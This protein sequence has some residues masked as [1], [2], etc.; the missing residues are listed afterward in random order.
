M[1]STAS[2]LMR[3]EA[4]GRRG[5]PERELHP[6]SPVLSDSQPINQAI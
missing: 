1:H 6:S 2:L 3:P 5:L 4:S